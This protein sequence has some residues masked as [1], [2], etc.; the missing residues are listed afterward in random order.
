MSYPYNAYQMEA[1]KLIAK[2]STIGKRIKSFCSKYD[3]TQEQF[4]FLANAF[5]KQYG[6]KVTQPDISNYV[7]G[8]YSPKIDKLTAIAMA[9]QCEAAWFAGYGKSE[10]NSKNP[11]LV[12]RSWKK[13][14]RK[15]KAHDKAA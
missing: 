6:T 15:V 14:A 7:N 1:M 2:P 9:T 13:K 8:K 11:A 5:G 3:L 10:P 4:A 12:I